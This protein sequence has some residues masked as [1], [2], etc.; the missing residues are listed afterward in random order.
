VLFACIA[1]FIDS[2]MTPDAVS[3]M[4]EIDLGQKTITPGSVFDFGLGNTVQDM[5]EAEVG[6]HEL[7][8]YV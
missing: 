2:N 4:L 7:C 8:M 6:M 1:L 3:V 5:W